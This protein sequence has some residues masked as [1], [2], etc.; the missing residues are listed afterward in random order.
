MRRRSRLAAAVAIAVLTGAVAGCGD[1]GTAARAGATGDGLC[2]TG[3]GAPHVLAAAD[4]RA[5]TVTASDD[6]SQ[7]A[8]WESRT[9]GP[10]EAAVRPPG[11]D[12]SPARPVGGP[13]ALGPVTG[14]A[15]GLAVVAWEGFT[16][17]DR[18]VSAAASRHGRWT[19]PV[20]LSR[21]G[22]RATQPAAAATGDAVVVGWTE[23][24]P[25]AVVAVEITGGPG[26]T[27]EPTVLA[28]D[29]EAVSRLRLAATGDGR[30]AAIWLRD[31]ADGR[32]VEAAV[33]GRTGDWSRPTRLSASGDDAADPVLAGG[34]GAAVAAWR[35]ADGRRGLR[36]VARVLDGTGWSEERQLTAGVDL[37]RGEARSDVG[38]V[39]PAA[40]VGVDGT[41]VVA[42][43]Q[44]RDGREEVV[45]ATWSAAGG[46]SRARP[47]SRSSEQAGSPAVAVDAAGRPVVA[48]ESLAGDRQT[49]RVAVD[50]APGCALTRPGREASAPRAAAGPGGSVTAVW[51]DANRGAIETADVP[52]GTDR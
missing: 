38:S 4:R 31:G 18:V 22:R 43:P 16:T 35:T 12:W 49:V 6:G 40:A 23:Q 3:P 14:A 7:V 26:G 37:P 48:W 21:P 15:G 11:G 33:R 36:L 51:V 47:V 27:G 50:G 52:G 8:A 28:G 19:G 20:V 42:W 34:A 17:G 45:T 44:R 46:W 41:A 39:A 9:G 2:R 13:N 29:G 32:V 30:V 1:P 10:V 24:D 5:P 25:A